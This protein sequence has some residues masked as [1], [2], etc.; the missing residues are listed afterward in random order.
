MLLASLKSDLCALSIGN[1]DTAGAWLSVKEQSTSSPWIMVSQVCVPKPIA[2][3]HPTGWRSYR[4]STGYST[5]SID[6][7]LSLGFLIAVVQLSCVVR[8]S[9]TYVSF[10]RLAG[11]LAKVSS[12]YCFRPGCA[13]QNTH[14]NA[15]PGII[16]CLSRRADFF[17][18]SQSAPAQRTDIFSSKMAINPSLVCGTQCNVFLLL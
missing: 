5:D 15:H 2:Q 18:S 9:T 8:H 13:I 11:R 17:G 16:T 3:N 7:I 6:L 10:R 4:Q 1:Q 12:G 14:P